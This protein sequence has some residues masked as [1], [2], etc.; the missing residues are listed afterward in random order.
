M[1]QI[2]DGTGWV[3]LPLSVPPPEKLLDRPMGFEV[4][5]DQTD[6]GFVMALSQSWTRD[7]ALFRLGDV[8]L[9]SPYWV[10]VDDDPYLFMRP[11]R[12]AWL[13]ISPADL[14]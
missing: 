14:S 4:P 8:G 10:Q 5:W 7:P 2:N 6:P 11:V 13:V 9:G 12:T 3:P 1:L